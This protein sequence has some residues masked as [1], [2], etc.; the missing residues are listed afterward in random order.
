[1]TQSQSPLIEIRPFE[2]DRDLKAIKRLW[3]E[4]AWIEDKSDA[5][6]LKHF[7]G[8]GSTLTAAMNGAAECAVH[9]TPGT[10]RLLRTD[11]PLCAVTAVTTSRIA[12]G[13][14]LARR[15]TALQL[16]A[17]AGEGAAI[18]SLGMF[19]QGFYDQ[20]GFANGSYSHELRFDPGQLKV[21]QRV[22]TP[23]RLK[24]S[25]YE[26]MHQALCRRLKH[27]GAV[28]LDPPSL[29]RAEFGFVEEGF[30]LGY[31]DDA[32]E[33]THFMWLSA[34][35]EHG[36]YE[37]PWLCYRDGAQLLELLG[38][39]KSLADQVYAVELEEPPGLQLQA[40][41]DR[42]FRHRRLTR[43]GN[44]GGYHYGAAWWQFRVLD[45]PACVAAL[46][47]PQPIE[48]ALELR[49]PVTEILMRERDAEIAGDWRGVGGRYRVALGPEGSAAEPLAQ[50]PGELPR[51]AAGVGAFTRL[52]WG[53][54]PASTL[55][56]AEDLA[57]PAPLLAALDDGIRLP[58]CVP[59]WDH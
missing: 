54:V 9:T 43:D 5:K 3:R 56:L 52:L 26:E 39:L 29:M 25:D 42:P 2:M 13:H 23:V 35:G 41:L 20:L 36:P 14:A 48:F 47:V 10:L 21:N 31:R 51:L 38:L 7:F 32:G 22:R 49:D 40:L 19:D 53:V 33:L 1:M 34:D 50:L 11:L 45:V 59:G 18:A 17:G 12:R 15:L 28:V 46:R 30:G 44:L 27:H 8:C 55:A 58:R 24:R 4:V 37:I 57:A 16:A 6:V